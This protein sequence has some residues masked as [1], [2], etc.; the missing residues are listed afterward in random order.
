MPPL[1]KELIAQKLIELSK[2]LD[3]LES[4]RV[5][6]LAEYKKDHTKRYAIERLIQLIVEFA[7][8]CNRYIVSAL[9]ESTPATYYDTFAE[10]QELKILPKGLSLRL[11]STTG[12]RNRLV[13]R[14]EE[15]DHKVVYHSILPLLENYRRYLIIIYDYLEKI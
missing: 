5:P 11:A 7:A 8:D 2:Y 12:L 10:M 6:S 14:Y 1:D 15:I 4:L 9:A 3:Q 13:H